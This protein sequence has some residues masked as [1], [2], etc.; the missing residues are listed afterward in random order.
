MRPGVLEAAQERGFGAHPGADF[1]QREAVL[2][3]DE[4]LNAAPRKKS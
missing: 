1:A 3:G 4:R 2:A